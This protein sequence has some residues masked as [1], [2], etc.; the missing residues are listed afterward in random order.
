MNIQLLETGCPW[1]FTVNG[2]EVVV[3]GLDIQHRPFQKEVWDISSDGPKC[4]YRQ[5]QMPYLADLELEVGSFLSEAEK[6]SLIDFFVTN[7]ESEL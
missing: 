6:E 2:R 7:L 5:A 4:H 1:V 3:T